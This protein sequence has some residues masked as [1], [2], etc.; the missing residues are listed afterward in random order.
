MM[1]KLMRNASE[2]TPTEIETLS[3][4][5]CAPTV[6][7]LPSESSRRSRSRSRSNT[8]DFRDDCDNDELPYYSLHDCYG[9]VIDDYRTNQ[10]A[11]VGPRGAVSSSSVAK[12]GSSGGPMQFMHFLQRVPPAVVMDQTGG[13]SHTWSHGAAWASLLTG[14]ID[15]KIHSMVWL[16]PQELKPQA[17][18]LLKSAHWDG[19]NLMCPPS[20]QG[21][22]TYAEKH[23]HNRLVRGALAFYIGITETP[24][25]R[26]LEHKAKGYRVM[27][28]YILANSQQSGD[29]E[30]ALILAMEGHPLCMNRSGG[31]ELS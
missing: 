21:L 5:S 4:S 15:E 20:S 25:I 8:C 13:H 23:I 7:D 9:P 16:L 19:I 31:G 2:P 3:Q 27:D 10:W 30:K 14:G 6:I 28:L 24:C 29:D 17:K 12:A 1:A 11:D 26:F 18:A 22:V